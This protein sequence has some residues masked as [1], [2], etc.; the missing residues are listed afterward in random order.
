LDFYSLAAI[1]DYHRQAVRGME[2]VLI[3]S[4]AG[5]PGVLAGDIWEIPERRQVGALPGSL[6]IGR[7]PIPSSRVSRAPAA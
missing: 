6:R 3:A 5:L 4:E 1:S 2:P 7:A